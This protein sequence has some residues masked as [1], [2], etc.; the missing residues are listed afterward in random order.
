M[1][2]FQ[3]HISRLRG[4]DFRDA[5]LLASCLLLFGALFLMLPSQTLAEENPSPKPQNSERVIFL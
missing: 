4:K 2:V 3:K 5:S 1:P